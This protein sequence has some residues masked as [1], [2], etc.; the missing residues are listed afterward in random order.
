MLRYLKISNLAI[1]DEVEVEF[2]DGFN[3]LTGETGAG[4]SILIGALNLLLGEKISPDLIRTDA[5]EAYVEGLF[6]IAEDE[7]VAR[8]LDQID[9]SA[10]ELILAR[11][12]FRSGRSRALINGHLATQAQLQTLG[13]SLVSI[14]GQH[15]HQVLLDP[16]EHTEILDRVGGLC[17]L[18]EQTAGAHDSLVRSEK[19]LET[20]RHRIRELEETAK[21]NAAIAEELDEV[22]L[23]AGEEDELET[24]RE[25]LSKAVQIREKAYEAYETLYARSGSLLEG[26]S[27]VRK[28]VEFLAGV[29]PR[30]TGLRE[31]LE[32]VIYRL[33]DVAMELRGVAQSAQSNPARLEIIEER[34]A[35]IRRLKR[36]H[37]TDLEGLLELQESLSQEAGEILDVRAQVKRLEKEAAAERETY[38]TTA[39][40]LSDARKE[41]AGHLQEAM[42]SELK[43]LAMPQA[44]FTVVFESFDET[45]GSAKGM[46]KAEFFLTAN[47]GEAPRPLARIAS[48]GEL[49]RIM[50]AL[51][52]LQVDR[53]GASTVIFDEVDAGIGGHTATA[54]GTRLE[55][56][57]Q[58][59]Q[60]LCVTHLHQ[61]AA[62][63]NHHISVHKYV[64]KGRTRTEVRPLNQDERVEEI[65]R[66]LGASKGSD[67]VKEHVRRLMEIPAA[68]VSQ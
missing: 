41:A 44:I 62:M 29:N 34:L 9:F 28:A 48:G 45:R 24:E 19:A 17:E 46:E 23:R 47:P 21:E 42:E 60:V 54:V 55:R 1:I 13:R 38:F 68:E 35:L 36:K 40:A 4:K 31:N 66:M 63:A 58:R 12:I 22:C 53:L 11:R 65:T 39:Q 61:I 6:E 43:E 33:E 20:A 14:F 51:K 10:G 2:A 57:A 27:D 49:S 8:D 50:L 30:L 52:A 16:D 32:D 26:F 59:Q 18:C 5:D 56:V 37:S 64:R 15:E 3:V 25:T 7:L 67:A